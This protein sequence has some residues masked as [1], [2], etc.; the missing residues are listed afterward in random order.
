MGH[1]AFQLTTGSGMAKNTRKTAASSRHKQLTRLAKKR[2]APRKKAR[3]TAR[4]GTVLRPAFRAREMEPVPANVIDQITALAAASKI[5]NYKWL[6]LN[7]RRGKAP[8]AYTKGMAVV[9]A[10]VYC[11]L[12]TGD[13][14]AVLM[15]KKKTADPGHDVLAFYDRHFAAAGMK[16]D[17]DGV[18]TLRHLFVLMVG[19]GVQESSGRYCVGRYTTQGYA[20]ADDAEA[21]LFQASF[22]TTAG[23]PTIMKNLFD[24]YDANPATGFLDV[25]KERV[26]CSQADWKNWGDP[27]ERGYRWQQLTKSCPAFAVEF[28]AVGLR[29][30][31]LTWGQ[32]I[33]MGHV[34]I[35]PDCDVM[36]KGVETVMNSVPG[37]CAQV[38]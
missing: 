8:L 22:N 31:R 13:A 18:E 34:E 14:A 24:H 17:T 1:E 37:L 38:L 16:N 5:A 29:T 19:L 28:A 21:G 35:V 27:S 23:S 33:R 10:R 2:A 3:K 7:N 6:D 20:H 15:A 12:K 4:K 9:Y 32:A 30:H 36:F 26:R 11:K 25:F